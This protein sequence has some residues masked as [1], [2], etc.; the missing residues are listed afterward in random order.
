MEIETK[1]SLPPFALCVGVAVAYATVK[2]WLTMR[3]KKRPLHVGSYL[4][5]MWAAGSECNSD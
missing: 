1:S 3:I 4:W 5:I 2:L